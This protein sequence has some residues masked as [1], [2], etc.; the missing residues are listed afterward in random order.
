[1]RNAEIDLMHGLTMCCRLVHHSENVE[2]VVKF[3]LFNKGLQI[4]KISTQFHAT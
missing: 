3:L 4:V 1:M 2:I